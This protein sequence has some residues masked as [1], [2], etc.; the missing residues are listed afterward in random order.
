MQILR[1]YGSHFAIY[2]FSAASCF[3]KLQRKRKESWLKSVNSSNVRVKAKMALLMFFK[4]ID[5]GVVNL[6]YIPVKTK[7]V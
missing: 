7:V 1:S 3:V 5:I 2:F 4:E 6:K